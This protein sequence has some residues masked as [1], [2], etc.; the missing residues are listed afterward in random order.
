MVEQELGT[1]VKMS[2]RA[3][4]S[5]MPHEELLLCSGPE[6]R[7]RRAMVKSEVKMLVV[8][9]HQKRTLVKRTTRGRMKGLNALP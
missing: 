1:D 2:E 8:V 9:H 6:G 5:Q 7:A 3:F 4:A